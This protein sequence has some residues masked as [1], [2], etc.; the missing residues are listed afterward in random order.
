MRVWLLV[1]GWI[2]LLLGVAPGQGAPGGGRI[3]VPAEVIV[4]ADPIRVRDVAALEGAAEALGDVVIGPAPGAGE[5]RTFD[6]LRLLDTLKRNGLD[7]SRITYTLPPL[8][9][10]RRATQDVPPSELK[11]LVEAHLAKELGEGAADASVRAVETAGPVLV[12]SG[13]WTATVT[14]PPGTT[15]LG[16]TRLSIEFRQDDKVVR[17]A[18]VTAD[19]ARR[20]AVVVATRAVGRGET[21]GEKDVAVQQLD[22]SEL[23]RS[24]VP[25]EVVGLAVRQPLLPWAPVRREQVGADTLVRRGDAVMIVASQGALRITTPGEVR[26]DAGRGE[27]VAVVNRVSGKKIVGRVVDARTVA[28]EF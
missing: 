20:A 22:L 26:E 18:W 3:V 27:S 24:I 8:L 12:P 14:A 13:P 21:L 11:S 19:I 2:A 5:S 25:A 4:A 1:L 7:P 15:L 10:V 16:R 23:P 6:G 28:V 17:T 9:R